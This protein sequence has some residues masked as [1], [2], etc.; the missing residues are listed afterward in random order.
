[1]SCEIVYVVA[2]PYAADAIEGV[3]FVS[4]QLADDAA[5]EVNGTVIT[6]TRH[7]FDRDEQLV[8]SL[9]ELKPLP[10]LEPFGELVA[11][12]EPRV[13]LHVDAAEVLQQCAS[14]D[15]AVD[16][17]GKVLGLAKRSEP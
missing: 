11:V 6:L 17:I 9:P 2:H 7:R 15:N 5:A 16:F 14:R 3:F 12:D 4:R 1:M 10:E 13:T 8:E